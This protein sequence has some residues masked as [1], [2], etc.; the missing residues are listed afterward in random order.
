MLKDAL[1]NYVLDPLKDSAVDAA[2]QGT[3][4]QGAA[5]SAGHSIDST[6]MFARKMQHL[7]NMFYQ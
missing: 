1:G 6:V 2:L 7:Y 5:A 4:M 3:G